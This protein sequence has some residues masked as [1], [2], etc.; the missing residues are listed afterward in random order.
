MSNSDVADE[1]PGGDSLPVLFDVSA[2]IPSVGRPE[3]ARAIESVR[4]QNGD[5]SVE[6]IVVFDRADDGEVDPDVIGLADQV[7]FTGGGKRG[8]FARNQGVRAARST[9][10]AFLDDDDM[11]LPDKLQSQISLLQSSEAPQRTLVGGRHIHVDAHNGSRSRS[12]PDRLIRPGEPVAD[13][14]FRKRKPHV[15]RASMYTST[16]LCTRELA[17]R[18]EW[19]ALLSRHQDWDWLIQLERRG[20]AEFVQVEEAVALIQTGSETSISASTDWLGS[21]EWA[22]ARL[23]QVPSTYVDFL[24]AQTLRYAIA[25]RSGV[26][27][28]A[29][30]KRISAAKRV[31]SLKNIA[32]GLGGLLSRRSIEQMMTRGP[33]GLR[34]SRS[35]QSDNGATRPSDELKNE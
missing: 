21:M 28:R 30:L 17:L 26:G 11:W 34:I 20:G 4:A 12:V 6:V 18:V 31:P 19:D 27:A 16:L 14:L 5:F 9:Y 2:I 8:S 22:D 29:V 24:S 33:S 3:L 35:G 23:K 32:I 7:F 13:Y 10:V 15:G 25:S 1:S